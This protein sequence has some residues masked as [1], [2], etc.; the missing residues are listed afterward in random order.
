MLLVKIERNCN[1]LS[2]D[3]NLF[4]RRIL[5]KIYQLFHSPFFTCFHPLYLNF[6][7]SFFARLISVWL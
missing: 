1:G 4:G 3:V 5:D 7:Q 2:R 6:A